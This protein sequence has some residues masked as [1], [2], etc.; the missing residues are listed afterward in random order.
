MN[1][2]QALDE[3]VRQ[4]EE[5]GLYDLPNPLIRNSAVVE[6]TTREEHLAWCKQRALEL[7]NDKK[8]LD[9]YNS[10]QSDM[11]KHSETRDHIGLELG[12]QLQGAGWMQ[13]DRDVRHWITG[14]K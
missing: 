7:L 11:S 9:A 10:M 2:K 13:T 14:F 6:T 3:L 1:R 12:T 5:L 4:S 8:I